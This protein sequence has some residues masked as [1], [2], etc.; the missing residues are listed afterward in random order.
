LCLRSGCWLIRFDRGIRFPPS[1]PSPPGLSKYD[2]KLSSILK[3]S[4][5]SSCVGGV[6][7]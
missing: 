4:D 5:P 3:G 6:G 7:I 1:P 2:A